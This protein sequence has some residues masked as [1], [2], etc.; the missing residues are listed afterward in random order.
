MKVDRFVWATVIII[1][2]LLL[3]GV[4][5]QDAQSRQNSSNIK[6]AELLRMLRSASSTETDRASALIG[7][8]YGPKLNNGVIPD[9]ETLYGLGRILMAYLTDHPAGQGQ[10][11]DQLV[12]EVLK[13]APAQIE[14]T[15][16]FW[17]SAHK[18]AEAYFLQPSPENAELFYKALPDKRMP[19]LD[20]PGYVRL[21]DFVFGSNFSILEKEMVERGEPLAVDV[22]FRLI[23]I[24]DGDAGETLVHALG[25][26]V[27]KHPRLFLQKALAH[28]GKTEPTVFEMLDSI[29]YPVAWWETPEDDKE[30]VKYKQL[31]D[32]KRAARVKALET[33]NDP[34]LKA[35]RDRCIEILKKSV[36][37]GHNLFYGPIP[38]WPEN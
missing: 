10:S 12:M 3:R 32:C 9:D 15:K 24:S 1:L 27:L 7:G 2:S 35:I 5:A 21:G 30:E 18:A 17:I 25:E 31:Y 23:N 34:E 33:V 6:G 26:I 16:A 13:N 38:L 37:P 14:E 20:F 4:F 19:D 22:G 29:L 11:L 36:A 8:I 28:Q